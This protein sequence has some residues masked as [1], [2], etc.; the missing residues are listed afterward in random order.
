MATAFMASVIT[1]ITTPAAAAVSRNPACGRDSQENIW[2]GSTVNGASNQSKDTNGG[3]VVTGDGGRKAMKVSAPMVM[4]GAVSPM[5]RALPMIMPV[6]RP[7]G[8]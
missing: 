3:A 8:E 6:R 2:I 5:A 1:M 7:A 4:I